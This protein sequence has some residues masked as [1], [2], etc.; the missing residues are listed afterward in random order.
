MFISVNW[1]RRWNCIALHWKQFH[2]FHT[3]QFIIL[4]DHQSLLHSSI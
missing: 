2:P 4:T 1:Q 3:C